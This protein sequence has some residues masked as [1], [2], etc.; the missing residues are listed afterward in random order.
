V[1]PVFS[2]RGALWWLAAAFSIEALAIAAIGVKSCGNLG[3]G[4][5]YLLYAIP[6]F[7]VEHPWLMIPPLPLAF[8]TGG[9]AY[10]LLERYRKGMLIGWALL[11]VLV[12]IITAANF[13]RAPDCYAL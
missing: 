10:P 11:A 12:V 13:P 5:Y 6:F 1:Q 9:V 8:L 7:Y 4:L 2:F 3:W